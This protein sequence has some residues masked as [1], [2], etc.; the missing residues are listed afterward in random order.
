ML[1][2]VTVDG[3]PPQV[4]GDHA[5]LRSRW[6]YRACRACTVQ[7]R[8]WRSCLRLCPPALTMPG[9]LHS[10]VRRPRA[11]LHRLRREAGSR[12][13][14]RLRAE[15]AQPARAARRRSMEGCRLRSLV[16]P[17][18]LRSSPPICSN[19][20]ANSGAAPRA[21][22]NRSAAISLRRAAYASATGHTTAHTMTPH[23]TAAAAHCPCCTAWLTAIPT[24][25]TTA[26]PNSASGCRRPASP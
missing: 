20:E 23:S 18:A 10:E 14:H 17:R 8:A 24:A 11:A 9:H 3:R 6:V 15:S 25:A 26:M 13:P 12:H 19:A 21:A 7:H 5:R 16:T 22:A 1:P 2:I 4:L